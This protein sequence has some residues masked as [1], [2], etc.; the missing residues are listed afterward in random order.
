MLIIE[1]FSEP[2]EIPWQGTKESEGVIVTSSP[3]STWMIFGEIRVC[4]FR[5]YIETMSKWFLF[6][7]L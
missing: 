2:E 5:L 3:A 7:C 1:Q 6:T 4:G